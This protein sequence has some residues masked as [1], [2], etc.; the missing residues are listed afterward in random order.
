MKGGSKLKIK[1]MNRITKALII[2]LFSYI[3]VELG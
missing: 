2:S 1:K 3:I